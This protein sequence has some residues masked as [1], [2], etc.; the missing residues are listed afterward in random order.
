MTGS[1]AARLASS[2]GPAM[3]RVHRAGTPLIP[4]DATASKAEFAQVHLTR[5]KA[6]LALCGHHFSQHETVLLAA[7]WQVTSDSR[8][9]LV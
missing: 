3:E 5:G 2:P 1:P 8:G 6:T 4:C 9:T 7:G